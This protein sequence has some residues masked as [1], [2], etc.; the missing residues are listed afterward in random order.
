MFTG[1][2]IGLMGSSATA[3]RAYHHGDLRNAL[4]D[5]AAELA[6]AGG[7]ESVTIRA[8]ARVVG[9]TPTAAYRHFAGH[10]ELLLAAKERAMREMV[11]AMRAA[12]AASVETDDPVRN[13]L[14]RLAAAGRGYISFALA[15]PGLFRTFCASAP[16]E[17]D[18]GEVVDDDPFLILLASLDELVRVGYLSPERRELAEFT[19]WS[20]VHGL[21]TLLDGPLRD[22]PKE[23]RDEAIARSF[24]TIGHG[25][26]GDGL[27]PE[28]EAVLRG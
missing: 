27:T 3:K 8:A 17:H 4:I 19:A 2:N 13:A 20:L 22:L 11:T 1:V 16:R 12:L 23:V 18:H 26:A 15:Q 21:A 24:A 6:A 28:Q 10:E 5:A 9:V 25:L 7:P 14:G